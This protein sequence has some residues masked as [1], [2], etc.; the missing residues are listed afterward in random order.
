MK[1]K[2]YF[3]YGGIQYGFELPTGHPV[4]NQDDA[5]HVLG[6]FASDAVSYYLNQ[7]HLIEIDEHGQRKYFPRNIQF[8]KV[9]GDNVSLLWKAQDFTQD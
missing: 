5:S 7:N 9:E 6:D 3:T 1:Y 8:F 2:I 4:F